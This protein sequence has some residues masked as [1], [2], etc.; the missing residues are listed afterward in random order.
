M[1]KWST[2]KIINRKNEMKAEMVSLRQKNDVEEKK[3]GPNL[4]R[5]GSTEKWS[6]TKR[7]QHI[8]EL[9]SAIAKEK[10]INDA[11][12]NLA[13]L[14]YVSSSENDLKM[15]RDHVQKCCLF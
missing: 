9:K 10:N 14:L 1:I 8:N 11:E 4:L 13:N 2:T 3:Q 7:L 15:F 6:S 12:S 5:P